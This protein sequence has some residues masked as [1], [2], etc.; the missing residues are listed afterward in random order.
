MHRIICL[1]YL[2]WRPKRQR[3][4]GQSPRPPEAGHR[5]GR[6]SSPIPPRRRRPEPRQKGPAR[7]RSRSPRGRRRDFPHQEGRARASRA[8]ALL[9]ARDLKVRRRA[10]AALDA[11]VY[12]ETSKGPRMSRLALWQE[13]ATEAGYIPNF[14]LSAAQ[15]RTVMACLDHGKFISAAQYMSDARTR[16]IEL[17]HELDQQL[18]QMSV[19]CRRASKRGKP[20]PQK[21]GEIY[22]AEIEIM[23]D[24]QEPMRRAGPLYPK[25]QLMTAVLFLLR[26]IELNNLTL[27][28]SSIRFSARTVTL[29]LPVSKMDTGGKGASR[30]HAC[31]CKSHNHPDDLRPLNGGLGRE[32]HCHE[33][34]C[35]FCTL[36]RHVD[37]IIRR[38][39]IR[40]HEE[41][42]KEFPLFPRSDGKVVSKEATVTSWQALLATVVP[43]EEAIERGV[44][45]HTGRRSGA[46]TLTRLRWQREVVQFFGRWAGDT[47]DAYIEEVRGEEAEPL[48]QG[49]FRRDPLGSCRDGPPPRSWPPAI[50]VP[51]DTSYFWEEVE[52]IRRELQSIAEDVSKAAVARREEIRELRTKFLNTLRER[53]A[54]L[55]RAIRTQPAPAVPAPDH[56][57]VRAE[58]RRLMEE[59]DRYAQNTDPQSTRKWHRVPHINAVGPPMGI[60]TFCGWKCGSSPWTVMSWTLG[61]GVR[62]GTCFP[63]QAPQAS[64]AHHPQP[65]GGSEQ[66]Q[67]DSD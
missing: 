36:K 39:D 16:H 53:L 33:A 27:H 8:D 46:K 51:R 32:V 2:H 11:K 57:M 26:E 14:P 28:T 66:S 41:R 9:A 34:V 61:D 59:L 18:E 10:E 3:R 45:G 23:V 50:P 25:R 60:T 37:D 47:V 67:S 17:G 52:E 40:P 13:L 30:T 1:K 6:T 21:A 55:R 35:I 20:A 63:S 19:R 4:W 22:L 43:L 44:K 31:C 54:P 42:A 15:I 12:A 29:H 49:P 58:V 5:R 24:T 38:F 62:C 56:D 7:E 64:N 65:P 48:D